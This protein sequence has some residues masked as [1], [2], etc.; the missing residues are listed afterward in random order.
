[1]DGFPVTINA[2][3]LQSNVIKWFLAQNVSFGQGTLLGLTGDTAYEVGTVLG[4]ITVGA[5]T[6]GHGTNTGNGLITVQGTGL[7]IGSQ[8]GVYNIVNIGGS[9][10]V[11]APSFAGTGNGVLTR[12]NPAF[13]AA[14]LPGTYKAIC[15][16]KTTD[17]GAFEVIRPDGTVDGVAIVGTA[18]DGQVKFTIADGSTDFAQGDTFSLVVTAVDAADSGV[19]SVTAPDGTKLPNATVGVAYDHQ[20]KFTIADGS[21]DFVVGDTFT[22][23]VA[24]GS[25]KYVQLDPAGVDGR[26][27]FAAILA[28]RAFIPA[29]TDVDTLLLISDGQV[30]ADALIWIDGITDD[31]IAAALVQAA[32]QRI[33]TKLSA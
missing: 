6:H 13:S 7:D 27:N 10:S 33:T 2:P 15:V 22:V 29:S 8:V 32:T 1:M 11:G 25:G 28:D 18:Y 14:V 23:T 21:T 17:S 9:F 12:A 20:V 24:A 30:L 26:Q 4:K 5:V 19:F 16:E 3:R 31:Q